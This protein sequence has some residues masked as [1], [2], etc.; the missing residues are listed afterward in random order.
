VIADIAV[1]GKPGEPKV[2]AVSREP[3]ARAEPLAA[4]PLNR[5]PNPSG[6]AKP[7]GDLEIGSSGDRKAKRRTAVTKRLE[8]GTKE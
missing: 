4:E 7:S 5:S 1:I 3:E 2:S 8:I 6:P